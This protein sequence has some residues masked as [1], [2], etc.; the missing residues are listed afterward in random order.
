MH[1][2]M[3]RDHRPAG[4]APY[5]PAAGSE[6]DSTSVDALGTPP[7]V[8]LAGGMV[9]G[10]GVLAALVAA[11]TLTGFWISTT[12]KLL[13]IG[14]AALAIAT[15]ATGLMLMRARAWASVAAVALSGLL[16][17]ATGGWLVLSVVSGLLSLFALGAPAV[18]LA[19]LTM[20][21]FALD[22][23]KKTTDA[24]ARLRADG[25]DLGA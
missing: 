7:F 8:R 12:L 21:I 20:S 2:V 13:L 3:T 17:L 10:A 18:A 24:R 15:S 16:L 1:D 23:C 14:L 19:A 5:L 22:P 9:L 11:Q 25:F 4:Q 6:A